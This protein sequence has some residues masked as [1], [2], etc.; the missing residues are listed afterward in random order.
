MTVTVQETAL[1]A[2]PFVVA[3]PFAIRAERPTPPR[4]K[5]C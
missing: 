1:T 2:T 4:V 3:A 5:R